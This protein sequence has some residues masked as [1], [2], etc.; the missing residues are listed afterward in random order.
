MLVPVPGAFLQGCKSGF[1]A[2]PDALQHLRAPGLGAV[3]I[4]FRLLLG[5]AGFIEHLH[6]FGGARSSAQPRLAHRG[7][8]GAAALCGQAQ[9]GGRRRRRV[10]KQ[11]AEQ[12][13]VFEKRDRRQAHTFIGITAGALGEPLL[14][15][16]RSVGRQRVERI[17][18]SFRL[19]GGERVAGRK[20]A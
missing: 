12:V 17:K 19:G 6:R 20:Q 8:I 13:P 18:P 7:M 4:E 11:R 16:G 5:G 9:G 3:E 2:A 1:T 14:L 15:G 10:L